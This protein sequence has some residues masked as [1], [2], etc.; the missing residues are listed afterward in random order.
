MK[1][2]IWYL[3][4]KT[5]EEF[6][7]CIERAIKGKSENLEDRRIDSAKKNNWVVR[8]EEMS[9]FMEDAMDRKLKNIAHWQEQMLRLYRVSRRRIIK[10]SIIA[11]FFYLFCFTLHWFG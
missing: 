5:R 9:S 8:I 3:Y 6:V 4:P 1:T 11:S 10:V 2:K 7:E